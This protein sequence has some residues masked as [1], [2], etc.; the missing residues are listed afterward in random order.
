MEISLTVQI[1]FIHG[2]VFKKGNSYLEGWRQG[3][4][5]GTFYA[6]VLL[7]ELIVL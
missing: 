7:D 1:K 5:R 4:Y 6:V 3:S 2:Y